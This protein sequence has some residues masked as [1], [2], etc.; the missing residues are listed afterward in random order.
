[1]QNSST[2]ILCYGLLGFLLLSACSTVGKP[3]FVLIETERE[4]VYVE[5]INDQQFNASHPIRIP[6]STMLSILR[7]IATQA[8]PGFFSGVL[9]N[10]VNV[11]TED[12]TQLLA[13]LFCEGL[14]QAAADQQVTFRL[15]HTGAPGDV[16]T[17]FLFVYRKSLYI[18][19]PWIRTESRYGAGGNAPAKTIVFSPLSA[20]RPDSYQLTPFSHNT[21]IVD[22]ELITARPGSSS[23]QL[24]AT[25]ITDLAPSKTTRPDSAQDGVAG[26]LRM[27]HDQMR[28]KKLEVETLHK[29]L[30]EMREYFLK[31]QEDKTRGK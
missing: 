19:L 26:Q 8:E 22:Y 25:D 10:P 5:R 24:S 21:V 6:E 16:K 7:G 2:S 20:K 18:T 1:M 14:M 4:E 9:P 15:N 13:P 29:E 27:L 12:Q 11:F 23:N 31:S 3:D 17:G 30:Q 28:A